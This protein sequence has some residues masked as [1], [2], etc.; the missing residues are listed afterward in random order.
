MRTASRLPLPRHN[1]D[2]TN[3]SAYE[4]YLKALEQQAINSYV[5]LPLAQSLFKEALAADPE[6]IDAK[7]ALA[8]NYQLMGWTGVINADDALQQA[9]PLIE[10]VL[11]TAPGNYLARALKLH[12]ELGISNKFIPEERTRKFQE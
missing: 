12:T 1:V 9:L 11:D 3:V 4:A 5:S 7:L 8:R 2:T 10:Q 6:F